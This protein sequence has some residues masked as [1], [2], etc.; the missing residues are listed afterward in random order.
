M[1][2]SI[3]ASIITAVATVLLA[4]IAIFGDSIRRYFYRPKLKVV[5]EHPEGDLTTI[6]PSGTPSRWYHLTVSNTQRQFPFHN[7]AVHLLELHAM[8]SSGDW[9]RVW[10]G[11]AA[12]GW[13]YEEI[14]FQPKTVGHSRDV[15][16]C[17][18]KKDVSVIKFRMPFFPN[19]LKNEVEQL[20]LAFRIKLTLQAFGDEGDS[21]KI[22]IEI[23]WDGVWLDGSN[24]MRN[25]F[26]VKQI[27]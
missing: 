2:V 22:V 1:R 21:E 10:R 25:H 16:L 20:S 14:G 24:E 11:N 6:S 8:H 13:R 4:A 27:F 23:S 18:V 19:N 12:L 3:T 7:V 9:T 26:R 17:Y 5:L 15:D